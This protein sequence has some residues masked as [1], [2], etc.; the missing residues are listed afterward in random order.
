ML[1]SWIGNAKNQPFLASAAAEGAAAI[2]PDGVADD[3]SG[4]TVAG[5][6]VR[7]SVHAVMML[8]EPP[9]GQVDNTLPGTNRD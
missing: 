5:V 4:I 8:A 7:R 3:L 1:L 2:Q 9:S 6:G